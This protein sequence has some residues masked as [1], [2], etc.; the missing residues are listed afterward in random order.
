MYNDFLSLVKLKTGVIL[1]YSL[2]TIH[3]QFSELLTGERPTK[4]SQRRCREVKSEQLKQEEGEGDVYILVP[5]SV[6]YE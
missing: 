5:C 2:S 1:S 3:K 6:E 4:T